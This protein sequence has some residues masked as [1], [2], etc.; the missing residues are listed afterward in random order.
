MGFKSKQIIFLLLGAGCSVAYVINPLV[1]AYETRAKLNSHCRQQVNI[2]LKILCII[3]LKAWLSRLDSG[4]FREGLSDGCF[5]YP[6]QPINSFWVHMTS[7]EQEQSSCVWTILKI[8]LP[9]DFLLT[10]LLA[11]LFKNNSKEKYSSSRSNPHWRRTNNGARPTETKAH[12]KVNRGI[13]H[14]NK[15]YSS[16]RCIDVFRMSF[17]TPVA[18][19][20]LTS[21]RAETVD[22]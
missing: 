17:K 11:N 1:L 5:S 13:F 22:T 15:K 7:P 12:N 20:I 18:E 8:N 10:W 9:I 4:C 19:V 16:I 2:L 3:L 14:I 6:N 21:I